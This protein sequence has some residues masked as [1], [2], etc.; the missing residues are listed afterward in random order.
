MRIYL[1]P[2]CAVPAIGDRIVLPHEYVNG[3][4]C[5]RCEKE[6]GIVYLYDVEFPRADMALQLIAEQKRTI[7]ALEH[8]LKK[9]RGI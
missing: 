5:E 7:E 1:H 3:R 6:R 9:Y 8:T 2:E 4:M